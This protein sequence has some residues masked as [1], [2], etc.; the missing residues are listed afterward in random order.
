MK[1]QIVKFFFSLFFISSFLMNQLFAQDLPPSMVYYTVLNGINLNAGNG[2]FRF[3][4][5]DDDNAILAA[6]LPPEIITNK[7]EMTKA[8]TLILKKEGNVIQEYH[9]KVGQLKGAFFWLVN[10]DVAKAPFIKEAGN[11]SLEFLFRDKLLLNF[12][13]SVSV[14]KSSDP[15]KPGDGYY[16]E[17][18]WKDYA[19]IYLKDNDPE[20][21]VWFSTWFRSKSLEGKKPKVQVELFKDG[22]KITSW[23][24]EADALFM[25]S[26]WLEKKFNFDQGRF[27]TKDL[28]KDGKYQ[29]VVTV[30]NNIYGK[31]NFIV[32]DARIKYID[33]QDRTKSDPLNYLEGGPDIWYLIR[34]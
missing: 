33:Q 26:Q 29:F 7:A 6:F 25:P 30:D 21:A 10:H 15:Y 8:I 19:F 1:N 16:L 4:T 23:K 17:G 34:E 27:K 2:V 28:L 3:V 12:P 20:S 18:T 14:E 5:G 31:Y 13:F 11:Y 24:K 32:K 9:W 22:K